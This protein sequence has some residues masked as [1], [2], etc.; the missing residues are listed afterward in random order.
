MPHYRDGF[1]QRV[2][3]II[4]VW[5]YVKGVHEYKPPDRTIRITGFPEDHFKTAREMI[6]NY[7]HQEEGAMQL[8]EARFKMGRQIQTTLVA[9]KEMVASGDARDANTPL[10]NVMGKLSTALSSLREDNDH[11]IVTAKAAC[12]ELVNRA[13][14]AM[15]NGCEEF[16]YSLMDRVRALAP[17][18]AAAHP[19]IATRPVID[20]NT[21]DSN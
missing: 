3:G 15:D 16:S 12:E 18:V 4:E 8:S 6:D 5:F 2:E 10:N 19:E 11:C 7:H 13:Q 17:L 9:L 21:D 20:E 14:R 1:Y